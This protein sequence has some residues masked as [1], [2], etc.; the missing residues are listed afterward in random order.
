MGELRVETRREAACLLPFQ[1][2][3]RSSKLASCGDG[4]C[5]EATATVVGWHGLRDEECLRLKVLTRMLP[6]SEQRACRH[7]RETLE[8]R[9]SS[10]FVL[11]FSSEGRGCGR[12][13]NLAFCARFPNSCGRGVCVHSCGSVHSPPRFGRVDAGRVSC[14]VRWRPWTPRNP[15]NSP[16]RFPED[17]EF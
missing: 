15:E 3:A 14:A 17:P 13:G 8:S 11:L 12:C 5:S 2:S 10:S 1:A 4:T 6:R 7:R 16:T 9:R